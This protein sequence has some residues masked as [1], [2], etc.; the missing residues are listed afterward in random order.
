[1][2]MYDYILGLDYT[3]Y[4]RMSAA[5]KM[6]TLVLLPTKMPKHAFEK[7]GERKVLTSRS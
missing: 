2:D 4:Q 6:V 3:H 5:K 1:M 7:H